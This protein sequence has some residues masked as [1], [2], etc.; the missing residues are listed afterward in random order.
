MWEV[1]GGLERSVLDEKTS[2]QTDEA[3]HITA[4]E[5]KIGQEISVN[6]EP[7]SGLDIKGPRVGKMVT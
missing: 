5:N 4:A 2:K 7:S 3:H 6:G 1:E